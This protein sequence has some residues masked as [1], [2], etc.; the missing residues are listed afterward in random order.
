L[1][2]RR[3]AYFSPFIILVHS[4]LGLEWGA[5]AAERFDDTVE[6]AED[7]GQRQYS[8]RDGSQRS[9]RVRVHPDTRVEAV[10]EQSRE[11]EMIQAIDRLR[12]I[13]NEKRKTVYILCSVPLDIHIDELV[14]WRQL[15]GDRRQS[16]ALA[17]CDEKGWDALPLAAK[18]LQRLLP[19]LWGTKKA[20]ERWLA[21][22][23]PEANGEII[24]VW[25]V[26][27]TYRPPGQTSWSKAL[28]RHGADPGAA[29][30]GC[31]G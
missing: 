8:T 12:L 16:D 27:N 4:H 10:V 13:H 18:E 30:A 29:L 25:G 20:A 9:V 2:T 5:T 31:W 28:V 17:E 21:K 1:A 26:L 19:N 22:N 14:T 3:A 15:T 6:G 7:E 23:P 24:R 11:A